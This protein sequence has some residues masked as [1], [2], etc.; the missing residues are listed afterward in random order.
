[1]SN[2]WG[3]ETMTSITVLFEEAKKRNWPASDPVVGYTGY[4]DQGNIPK[5][6]GK[7]EAGRRFVSMP[8]MV[9]KVW[10]NKAKIWSDKTIS[11][12]RHEDVEKFLGEFTVM[13]TF[14]QRYT[15]NDTLTT[16][17]GSVGTKE[18]ISAQMH[19]HLCDVPFT[20]FNNVLLVEEVQLLQKVLRGEEVE[21]DPNE[22]WKSSE[23][24][25]VRLKLKE[26]A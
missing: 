25:R 24:S 20:I 12:E 16:H 19:L 6:Y 22:L 15:D 21:W 7:D 11:D 5:T 10:Q 9:V 14:F 3:P 23:M 13:V 2:G 4:L 8:A 17:S 26:E 18:E 1:M